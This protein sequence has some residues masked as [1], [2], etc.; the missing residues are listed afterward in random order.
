MLIVSRTCHFVHVIFIMKRIFL[1]K[2]FSETSKT[3]LQL[4]Q[5]LGSWKHV[6]LANSSTPH[7]DNFMSHTPYFHKGRHMLLTV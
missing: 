6:P 7:E 4:S 5:T 2:N 3:P 1:K